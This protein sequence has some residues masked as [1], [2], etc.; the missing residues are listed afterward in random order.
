VADLL[1]RLAEKNVAAYYI[2]QLLAAFRKDQNGAKHGTFEAQAFGRPSVSNQPLV[3]PLINREL[4]ILDLL[5][6]RLRNKEIAAKLF[7]SPKTVKNTWTTSTVSSM[8][9]PLSRQ[10]IKVISWAF[11]RID[12]RRGR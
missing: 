3:E 5:P 10:L 9:A 4:E 12:R 2:G 6:Q 7:I 1:N 11:S 8:S